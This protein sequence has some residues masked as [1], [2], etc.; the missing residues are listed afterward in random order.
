MFPPCRCSRQRLRALPDEQNEDK[1]SN[2]HGATRFPYPTNT[3][4]QAG[5]HVLILAFSGVID[6]RDER[7]G[8]DFPSD[9]IDTTG[10]NETSRSSFPLRRQLSA[11]LPGPRARRGMACGLAESILGGL[12]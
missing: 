4:T 12:S 8:V 1:P 9:S 11:C 2:R 10:E 5:I 6:A 3:R 7:L